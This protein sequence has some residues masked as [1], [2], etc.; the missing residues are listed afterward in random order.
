MPT[1][2]S[3]YSGREWQEL[4]NA[5]RGREVR[6]MVAAAYRAAGRKVAEP[7]RAKLAASGLHNAS[8][9][10]RNIRVR[11]FPKG[12]GF[13]VTVKPHG[14]TGSHRNRRGL[15]KPVLLFAEEGT[16]ERYTRRPNPYGRR[17]GRLSALHLLEPVERQGAAIIEK[18]LRPAVEQ[19]VWKQ[20]KK[21]G[22]D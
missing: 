12:T 21:L 18:E 22:W 11:P 16:K 3:I 2:K 20:A 19:A 13:M 17:H 15:L 7:A 5:F 4:L 9:M 6:Q 1:I 8:A 14:R 10:K